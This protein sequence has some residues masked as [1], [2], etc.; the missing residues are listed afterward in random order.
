MNVHIPPLKVPTEVC[1]LV[2][3]NVKLKSE[4]ITRAAYYHYYLLGQLNQTF[5]DCLPQSLNQPASL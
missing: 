2:E 5:D 3:G 1:K 4:K